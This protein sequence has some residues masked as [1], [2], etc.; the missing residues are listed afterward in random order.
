MPSG[1]KNT[2]LSIS[3]IEMRNLLAISVLSLTFLGWGVHAWGL[4]L[5]SRQELRRD[6]LKKI[7]KIREMTPTAKERAKWNSMLE[8]ANAALE[9]A[10]VEG[11]PR[12]EP[13]LWEYAQ[14]LCGLSS[15]YGRKR[16]YR[17]AQYLAKMCFQKAG[18]VGEKSREDRSKRMTDYREKIDGL[19]VM[20]RRAVRSESISRYDEMKVR[21]ALKDIENALALEEFEDVEK[22]IRELEPRLKALASKKEIWGL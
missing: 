20:L 19:Y 10:M 3:P 4:N 7:E 18:E 11:A 9:D 14:W 13:D 12:Y 22:G 16:E 5:P 15:K 6:V 2:S 8:R 1:Y 17:K 21:L